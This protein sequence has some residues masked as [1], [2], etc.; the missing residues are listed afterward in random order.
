MTQSPNDRLLCFWIAISLLFF[1]DYLKRKLFLFLV[2]LEIF[3]LLAR[4]ATE[5]H[6]YTTDE[7]VGLA[8]FSEWVL[9]T[10]KAKIIDSFM[11]EPCD[12]KV[13][14]DLII[15]KYGITMSFGDFS[16]KWTANL[17]PRLS[18]NLSFLATPSEKWSE[19]QGYQKGTEQKRLCFVNDTVEWGIKLFEE[20]NSLLT[21][22]KEEKQFLLPVHVVGK[23]FKDI[24]TRTTK[25]R[26]IDTVSKKLI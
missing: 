9:N 10:E 14:G 8:L 21:K 18:I 2:F 24:P 25:K 26:V 19:N 3:S 15:R 6:S 23:K 22:D 11:A 16:E 13:R 5:A 20:F 1:S 4:E 12:R 17:L 7:L